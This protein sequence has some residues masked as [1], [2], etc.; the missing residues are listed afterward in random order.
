VTLGWDETNGRTFVQ[1]SKEYAHDY[2]Y[3]PEPD[4]LPLEVSRQW[5]DELRAT[6]PELPGAKVERFRQQYGLT[7]EEAEV[8]VVEREIADWY[9]A[10][11]KACG[12]PRQVYNW[13]TGE[14]F[15]LLNEA[16]IPITE[17]RV[18]PT[19]LAELLR[20]VDEGTINRNTA[21]R[22]LHEMFATGEKA[23]A[24]VEAKGLAQVSDEDALVAL[25]EQVLA[26]H[27]D[28]VKRYRE[29]K[30]G[31]FGWFL[32]QVMKATRGKANPELV[33]KLLQERL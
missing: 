33:R 21:K 5:V 4:L 19:H 24:I 20:L 12:K 22:V 1:R 3:F 17:M 6:L 8:L 18:T 28:E 29:G 7:P 16:D 26:E 25:V 32:G 14:I 13:L 27:P 23:Q 31:L 10:A 9:E 15:R 30:K 2:R 11:V